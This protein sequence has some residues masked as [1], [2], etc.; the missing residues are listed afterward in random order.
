[1]KKNLSSINFGR[2]SVWTGL[3]LVLVAA[4]TL[5]ATSLIQNYFSQKSLQAEATS[6]AESR[7]EF[8]ESEIMNVINQAEAGVRNKVWIAKFC[9]DFPDSL[10]RVCQLIVEDN[11]V[12]VGSSVAMVP[13]YYRKQP[14]FAPYTYR[15]PDNSLV[16]R[17]LATEAYDYPSQEWFTKPFEIGEGYWSEPYV[18]V[19]GADMLM[20]TYSIPIKDKEGRDACVLTGD[21]SLGW[22]SELVYSAK[23]YPHSHSVL[24][25]REGMFMVSPK[26]EVELEE[27]ISDNA[28]VAFGQMEDS[29]A[30]RALN[31]AMMSGETGETTVVIHNRKEYV[32]Y[33]PVERTGWS[34]CIMI[35]EEDIFGAFKKDNRL[36]RLLQLLGL[37]ML[38]LILRSLFKSQLMNN[39]LKERKERMDSE[40]H[41]AS[42]IQMS[43]VPDSIKSFSERHDLDMAAA[44]IPAKEVGGDLYDFFIRDEKL[45][46]CIGDVSG[47]GVPASLVMAVTRTAFRTVSAHE[48]S[49]E[50]IVSSMNDCLAD[51][52]DNEMFVTYFCG[53]LNLKDGHVSYCNAGHNP[54]RALTDRIFELPVQPNLPLGVIKGFPYI[55]QEMELGYDDALFLYTDGLTEAENISHEQFGEKR[56]DAAL[57]V[58]LSAI[59]Y[60][61]NMQAEV[62][63]FVGNA[64]QSDDLTM[65][66]IHYLGPE[67]E[68]RL[69]MTNDIGQISLLA[70]FMDRV[71]EKNNLDPGLAMKL[72]LA[73]E[74]AVTNVIMYAYPEGT[75][76]KVELET[77]TDGKCLKFT[78]SD[79]GKAFDP[80]AAPEADISASVEDRKIGGLGIHL[81]RT[82][83]DEISYER[84]R[85][86][87]VLIMKKN[88]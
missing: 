20:T 82:I 88:I 24:L 47:K 54:P 2:R 38:I 11:P 74:E 64:P 60:L 49:P 8:V 43:M 12:L 57:R 22:L 46:F 17:S 30:F 56:L 85:G 34:M 45:F 68:N 6:R 10:P 61:K 36:I 16:N 35:P 1:M 19:G 73:I 77:A 39:Q 53:V 9:L 41:I 83:M 71:A 78:L 70:G 18:D 59:D 84:S 40:L 86:K 67:D 5:E 28:I 13:G 48:D 31:R 62:E 75:E 76:G 7:L 72:N 14:L 55:K 15:G 29:L 3:M 33:A 69:V 21:I 66:F 23:A 37:V 87:N 26:I 65:L 4:L 32:Y 52:N 79:S 25:S 42:Q 27:K 51:M 81:V 63:K 44:I 50:Q 80:T 58:R